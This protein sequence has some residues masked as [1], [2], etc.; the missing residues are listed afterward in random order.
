MVYD[1]GRWLF[2]EEYNGDN[3]SYPAIRK[4]LRILMRNLISSK[5]LLPKTL[6]L[7]IPLE[8]DTV[9]EL[10]DQIEASGYLEDASEFDIWGD[11]V[12]YTPNGE[13]I[14]QDIIS[15][16]GFRTSAPFFVF[17]VRTDHW[18]PMMMN[19]ENYDFTWNL[20]QYHLNY[21]RISNLLKKLDKDLGWKNNELLFNETRYL[22]IQAGYD[23][24]L[25]E[26]V[27]S[28]EYKKNPNLAF[29]LNAYLA[30]MK[31]A[32]ERYSR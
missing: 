8:Y 1:R 27:I 26:S 5:I 11:T 7:D 4:S 16:E 15:I 29:D 23:F 10:L 20:E 13:E 17:T 2:D 25:E 6:D 12:I 14:H 21:H 24:F 19:S 30:A 32:K 18:L 3:E 22:S 31:K 28:R 9:D